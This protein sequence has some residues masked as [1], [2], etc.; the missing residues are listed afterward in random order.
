MLAVLIV[1]ELLGTGQW[2]GT[3]RAADLRIAQDQSTLSILD[4]QRPVLRYRY[5][6][7]PMKPCADQLFSPAGVQV[8]RDSPPDHKHH[9]AL[10]F[11]LMVDDVIF[12]EEVPEAP[13][14]EEHRTIQPVAAT[15]RA[16]VDRAG[17]VQEIDW[18]GP[19][20]DKPLMVERR[21]V[22]VLRAADLGATLVE[23]RC[24]LQP[25]P[26]KDSLVLT[27]HHYHGLGMRFVESMDTGGRFFNADDAVGEIVRGDER[28]TPTKWCAIT[29]KAGDKAVTIAIFDH[30]QNRAIRRGCSRCPSPLPISPP[31]GTNGKSRWW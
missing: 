22:D 5:A 4:G 1:A 12:W 2:R 8:L 25:P 11:A 27:G 14:K 29:G 26:G 3:V 10:M 28:L 30:P 7:V 6:D 20:S 31:P 16:G 21:S 23:W 9:H 15:N 19:A 17:L 13:A 24:R 18:V